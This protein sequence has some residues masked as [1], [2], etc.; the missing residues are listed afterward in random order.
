MITFEMFVTRLT[1]QVVGIE[2]DLFIEKVDWVLP[3]ILLSG[4]HG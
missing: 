1:W 2:G 4:I 3:G